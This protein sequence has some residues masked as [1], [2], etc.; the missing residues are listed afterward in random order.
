MKKSLFSSSNIILMFV[1]VFSGLSFAG[2]DALLEVRGPGLVEVKNTQ[3]LCSVFQ[4]CGYDLPRGSVPRV[5]LTSFPKDYAGMKK[6]P[7]V[8]QKNMFVQSLLPMILAV[9]E[10]IESDRDRLMSFKERL[11]RGGHLRSPEKKWLMEL[12]DRYK[13][14]TH[15]IDELLLRVDVIPPSLALGQ[16]SLESGWGLSKAALE[17]NSTFGHMASGSKVAGFETLY[18]SVEQYMHNLNCHG[19]YK[20]LRVAR[21]EMRTQGIELCSMTLASKGLK[22]YSV[23]GAAY[24]KDV[25]KMIQQN[26]FKR[27]DGHTLKI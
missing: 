12:A 21:A 2:G 14:K 7:K 25:Q 15:N 9:N 11:S 17:K 8:E 3:E 27:Y 20:E 24:I 23:R 19:A 6:K 1:L 16:A 10:S 5:Y 26:D 22:K 18:H 13:L 4:D